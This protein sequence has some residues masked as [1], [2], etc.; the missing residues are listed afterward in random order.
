MTKV[1]DIL[2]GT[3]MDTCRRRNICY[4]CR[5][6]YKNDTVTPS[7]TWDNMT[8]FNFQG[9]ALDSIKVL[10]KPCE[11]LLTNISFEQN[12]ITTSPSGWNVWTSDL[13]DENTVRTEYGDA[14]DGDYKLTFWDDKE[15]SCSV[16][17]RIQIFRMEHINSQFGQRQMG[18]RMFYN[19]MQKLWRK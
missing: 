13:S 16:Y 5:V 17:K 15:Y 8:L 12:G 4:I 1:L 6:A 14:Y 3:R 7:N 19:F 18:N 9:N 2:L 11:N 10:N